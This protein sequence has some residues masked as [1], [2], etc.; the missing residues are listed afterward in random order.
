[1]KLKI[2]VGEIRKIKER[3]KERKKERTEKTLTKIESEKRDR[4]IK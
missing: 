2:E 3:K 1:M 4:K